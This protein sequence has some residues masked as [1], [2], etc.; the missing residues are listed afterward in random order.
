MHQRLYSRKTLH[1]SSW[2]ASYGL[3]FVR[4]L[5]KI[6]H[7]ITAPHCTTEKSLKCVHDDVIDDPMLT[8]NYDTD[9]SVTVNLRYVIINLVILADDFTYPYIYV[10]VCVCKW[11]YFKPILLQQHYYN[12]KFRGLYCNAAEFQHA[13]C[14]KKNVLTIIEI[15]NILQFNYV[16]TIAQ[17]CHSFSA[18]LT[19]IPWMVNCIGH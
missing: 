9:H 11:L 7:V 2:R 5:V 16:Y 17:L 19:K 1:I 12:G 18:D 13:T 15:C 8:Q 6:D 14:C 10:C 3:S 4:I